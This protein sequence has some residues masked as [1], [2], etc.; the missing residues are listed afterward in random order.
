MSAPLCLRP[1]YVCS[2]PRPDDGKG[3]FGRVGSHQ[4]GTPEFWGRLPPGCVSLAVVT[5]LV[6]ATRPRPRGIVC[7]RFGWRCNHIARKRRGFLAFLR[8]VVVPRRGSP[9][10]PS[11]SANAGQ[12]RPRGPARRA[13]IGVPP[14]LRQPTSR[15]AD[16]GASRRPRH[17]PPPD[18]KMAHHSLGAP[19]R[20]LFQEALVVAHHQLR[21]E[22]LHRVQGDSDHDQDRCPAEEE[23]GA[24]LVDEDGR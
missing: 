13:E 24:R 1:V 21:L 20:G 2:A 14:T 23:V 3:S 10:T 19:G 8:N 12:A 16:A 22:L 17:D 15:R 5:L 9:L 7:V 11:S 18:P 6:C 4:G